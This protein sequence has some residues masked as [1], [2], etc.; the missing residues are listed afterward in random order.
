MV[1]CIFES[2]GFYWDDLLSKPFLFKLRV[3]HAGISF[4]TQWGEQFYPWREI[5]SA[6]IVDKKSGP[7]IIKTDKKE[8]VLW[9]PHN[10]E[11]NIKLVQLIEEI[12]S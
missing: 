5:K 12:K 1:D 8:L 7:I 6:Q 9:N 3:E 11:E 4:D 10:M 2:D